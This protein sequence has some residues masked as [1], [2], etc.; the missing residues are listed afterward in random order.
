MADKLNVHYDRISSGGT[1]IAGNSAYTVYTPNERAMLSLALVDS[2]VEIGDEIVIHWGEAGG[3]YGESVVP[4]TDIIEIRAIVS[5][6]P[7]SRVAREDYRKAVM[8]T[9]A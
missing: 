2:S 1:D 8:G 4:A 5:Q 7:Y 9:V 3:G 6:A